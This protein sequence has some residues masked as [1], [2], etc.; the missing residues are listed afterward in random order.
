MYKLYARPGAGSAAI[1]ALL[2]LLGVAH[3]IIAVPKNPDKTAPQ[4]FLAINPRGQVPALRLPDNSIMTESAAMA[5]HL[6]D[7]HPEAGLAPAPGTAARAQYLRWIVY[8]AANAYDSD[9]RMYYPERYST[10]PGHASAIKARAVVDLASDFDIFAAQMGDG[11][12]ILGSAMSAADIYAAMLLSW[13]NDVPGLFA[14]HAKLKRLYEAVA[15]DAK[16]RTVWDR[17]E[18]P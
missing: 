17:N 11:P 1:E 5:I 9:L 6:A 4:W 16:V 3:E 7:A 8:M 14:K 12:F 15:A 18:M 10:D 2:A 13:S